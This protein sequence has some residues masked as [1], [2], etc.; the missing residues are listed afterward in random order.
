[1]SQ[2]IQLIFNSWRN[3]S[4]SLLFCSSLRTLFPGPAARLAHWASSLSLGPLLLLSCDAS[5]VLGAPCL[6]LSYLLSHFCGNSVRKIAWKVDG[7]RIYTCGNEFVLHSHLLSFK[8]RILCWELFWKHCFMTFWECCCWELNVDLKYASF[9]SQVFWNFATTCLPLH[10]SMF[11]C[12][13][14]LE[15]IQPPDKFRE[16]S[17]NLVNE[18]ITFRTSLHQECQLFYCY[19]KIIKLHVFLTI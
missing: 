7:L 12:S 16:K 11:S 2:Y 9:L 4:W 3:F 14:L 15:D 5:S 17:S 19:L 8:N 18:Q 1:M 13:G 6:P 10:G